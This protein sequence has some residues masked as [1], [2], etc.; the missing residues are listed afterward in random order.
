M[1]TNRKILAIGLMLLIAGITTT[2]ISFDPSQILKYIFIGVSLAV[3]VLGIAVGRQSKKNFLRSKYYWWVGLILFGVAISLGIW[4]TTLSG[5]INVLGFFLIL[6]GIIEFVFAQQILVYATP[7]P[8]RLV[9]LKLVISAITAT[10]AAWILTMA[11]I[12]AN[13]ALLFMGVLFV[14]IGLAFVQ[15]SRIARQLELVPG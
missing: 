1:K 12:S 2:I 6:L 10:G 15:V 13:I 5:F 9:G 7:T 11:G 3:G 14:L 4:A 8:W